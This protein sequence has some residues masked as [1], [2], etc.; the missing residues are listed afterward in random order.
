MA[1]VSGDAV[2]DLVNKHMSQLNG[3]QMVELRKR[4]HNATVLSLRV[5]NET[6]SPLLRLSKELP[7][8]IGELVFMDEP[9]RWVRGPGHQR[10][11]KNLLQTSF[12]LRQSL[13]STFFSKNTIALDLYRG[14]KSVSLRPWLD[15]YPFTAWKNIK[16]LTI[17][18][19]S[20][21]HLGWKEV[22]KFIG[23]SCV[24]KSVAQLD[25]VLLEVMHGGPAVFTFESIHF[26]EA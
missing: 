15:R 21:L 1:A 9:E 17:N 10:S 4:L 5:T 25:A 20:D 14:Q 24:F 26:E 19:S 6:D 18:M 8:L 7:I 23:R 22:R 2:M 3:E 13:A 11:G 12:S 16:K